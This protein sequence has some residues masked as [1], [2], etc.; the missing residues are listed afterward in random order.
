MPSL[1]SSARLGE[2]HLQTDDG[3][4]VLGSLF[5]NKEGSVPSFDF[6]TSRNFFRVSADSLLGLNQIIIDVYGRRFLT[7]YHDY[8]QIGQDPLYKVF[9]LFN[10]TDYVPWSRVIKII[11]PLTQLQKDTA[12]VT[13]LGPVWISN[14]I[15]SREEID[16]T[17]RV[18]QSS[19]QVLTNAA[20]QLND[21]LDGLHVVRI[22][23]VLGVTR[24]EIQ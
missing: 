20:L 19:R 24:A 14:E 17:F 8:A 4:D 21:K 9:R 18:K 16:L 6:S 5:A 2:S 12:S 10:L 23:T 11:D 3:M 13:D 22:D 7:A 15:I 1:Q